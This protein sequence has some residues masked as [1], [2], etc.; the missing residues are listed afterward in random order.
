MLD[1]S[2]PALDEALDI[3]GSK[4]TLPIVA[5]LL[6]NKVRF[7]DIQRSCTVCPRTL[8]AR[9]DELEQKGII[10]TRVV[11]LDS[12]R[13]EYILTE[14][15]RALSNVLSAISQWTQLRTAS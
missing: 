5:A 13:K 1:N 4:W 10:Q 7:N 12:G 6:D 8:S 9:L 15:G 2:T 3:I 11:D 14:K